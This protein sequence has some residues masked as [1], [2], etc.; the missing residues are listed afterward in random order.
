MTSETY[1]K[2][3]QD[4]QAVDRYEKTIYKPGGHDDVI[5]QVEQMLMHR[6]LRRHR[7]DHKQAK[8][9]DFACGTG[10]VS[11]FMHPLVKSLVCCDISPQM[12]EKARAKLP[13]GDFRCVNI[14]DA[15][16]AVPGDMDLITCFRFLLLAEPKLREAVVTKL[17]TKL[18]DDGVLIFSLH[19]NPCSYR[20]IAHLRNRLITRSRNPLK[21]FGMGDMRRL[22]DLAGL[23]I[24]GATGAGYLPHG[25]AKLL[26]TG[27]FR[28]FE[29]L[30]AGWPVLWRFGSN[31]LVVCKRK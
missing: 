21:H 18:A 30:F 8:A 2:H 28:G 9:M 19:G 13:E 14:L 17:A 24:V 12:L 15:P 6:L 29:R 16:E 31:L 20:A 26:P 11:V 7:P 4:Q 27:L 23:R 22:A 3:Y 10:R 1:S 5:W 25:I